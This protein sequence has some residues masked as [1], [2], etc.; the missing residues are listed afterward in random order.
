[1]IPKPNKSCR[2]RGLPG[3]KVHK[4][5]KQSSLQQKTQ[6]LLAAPLQDVGRGPPRA[7]AAR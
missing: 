1:M 5:E 2:Q 6:G 3:L 7:E 4:K